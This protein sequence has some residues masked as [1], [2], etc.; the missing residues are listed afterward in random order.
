VSAAGGLGCG[1]AKASLSSRPETRGRQEPLYLQ[2]SRSWDGE[3]QP[4]A[5][6]LIQYFHQLSLLYS[7]KL[8][9]LGGERLYHHIEVLIFTGLRAEVEKEGEG[10]EVRWGET[11]NSL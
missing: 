1:A 10:V 3:N 4:V 8:F 9:L 6:S 2:L 11:I 7:E 5:A